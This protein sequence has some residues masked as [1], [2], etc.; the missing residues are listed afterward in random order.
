MFRYSTIVF[1]LSFLVGCQTTKYEVPGRTTLSPS[2]YTM[3]G[4]SAISIL[5]ISAWNC[6]PCWRYKE[7]DYPKW[8]KSDE[9]KHVKF[10]ELEFP[11]YHVVNIDDGRPQYTWVRTKT[12]TEGGAPRWIVIVDG[13]IISNQ[14]SWRRTYGLIQR[15]VAI[16]LNI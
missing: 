9:Y 13:K 14:K 2:S 8:I 11:D 12:F 4:S 5:Y 7:R 1:C 6:P 16:K 10:E 15:L 3:S